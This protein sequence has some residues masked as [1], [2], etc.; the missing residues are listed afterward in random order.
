M[1]SMARRMFELVEPIGVIPYSADEPNEAMFAL[2]FT[3]YWDTYF[4]G[5]AAPLGL[6][7]AQVVDALFYNFAP[8]E[9]A[10]HI[11]KVWRTTTPRAAIAAREM[12][13]VKALRR[14]LGD[15]VDAPA[16][17]RAADL[18]LTA[19]TSA[20]FEGRPMY[21]ALRAIPTP[22]DVVARL[23]HAA[24]LL[25]E[26]RGDGHIAALVAA[27]VAG[28]EAHVL[29][30]PAP[31]G[32]P[33]QIMALGRDFDDDEWSATVSGVAGRSLITEQGEL[34][35]DGVALKQDIEDRT[36]RIAL[37][38]YETLSD[39]EVQSLIDGLSPIAKA[40]IATGDFPPITPIGPI[41]SGDDF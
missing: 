30:H 29:H 15:H 13:C 36:D 19:A 24:S 2:G 25:R 21:A 20:P 40:I 12:G 33:P 41:A 5:R 7:P 6:A 17:A 9:V 18:L 34:T 23:F 31:I 26:H 35:A 22:D 37:S 1:N 10:R 28:R 3:N 16:F 4:A 8:G 32:P 38:A 14:I 39:H 11:P 27:G